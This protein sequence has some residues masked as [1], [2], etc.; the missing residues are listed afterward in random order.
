MNAKA[1]PNAN[2]SSEDEDG[3]M[4]TWWKDSKYKGTDYMD[5]LAK[6]EVKPVHGQ[7]FERQRLEVREWAQRVLRVACENT[8]SFSER[9]LMRGSCE[10]L[11]SHTSEASIVPYWAIC[12]PTSICN[13]FS[14]APTELSCAEKE[15]LA[16]CL[17]STT[18]LTKPYTAF[19]PSLS[20]P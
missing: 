12:E 20:A 10:A 18:A 19:T 13:T 8:S 9:G 11:S 3:V 14:N 4:E 7:E 16:G 2:K 1:E 15:S 6:D 5:V 17:L